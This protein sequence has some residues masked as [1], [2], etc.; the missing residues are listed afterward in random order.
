[1]FGIRSTNPPETDIPKAKSEPKSGLTIPAAP[2]V[3]E[4]A[5]TESDDWVRLSSTSLKTVSDE[6]Q[7]PRSSSKI[8]TQS[9][10]GITSGI[11]D[12]INNAGDRTKK[13]SLMEDLFGGK[14]RSN[15]SK[16]MF[17]VPKDPVVVGLDMSDIQKKSEQLSKPNTAGYAPSLSAPRDGRRSRKSS[18][19]IVDPLGMFSSSNVELELSAIQSSEVG[20]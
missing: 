2:K 19:G 11:S 15:I 13:S 5:V 16:D 8:D 18:G 17:I 1:M 12:R 20:K 3:A 4:T 14:P 10:N 6:T 9:N 7:R